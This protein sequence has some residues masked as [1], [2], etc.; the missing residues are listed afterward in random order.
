MAALAIRASDRTCSS[1]P[2]L[3]PNATGLPPTALRLPPHSR[4]P[5][6]PPR[7]CASSTSSPVPSKRAPSPAPASAV[8]A[9]PVRRTLRP[10][11]VR[12]VCP[13]CFA[14][15]GTGALHSHGHEGLRGGLGDPGTDGQ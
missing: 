14:V 4:A 12:I 6:S 5:P 7:A 15:T 9:Y 11:R 10:K 2:G 8:Y 13:P 3:A 1:C